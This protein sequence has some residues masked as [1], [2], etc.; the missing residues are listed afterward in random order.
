VELGAG[1]GLLGLTA[2]ALGGKVT[3][4]DRAEVLPL[5]RRGV[6]HNGLGD[7]VSVEALVWGD[8]ASSEALLLAAGPFDLLLMSDVVYETESVPKLVGTLLTLCTDVT[9]VLL[10]QD[11]SFG[12]QEAFDH[13]RA[14]V[15][16]AK[17]PDGS[18]FT[19]QHMAGPR[20]THAPNKESVQIVRLRRQASAST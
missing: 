14:C 11:A 15:E 2:A 16:E 9:E 8:Q 7:N 3:L 13:F 10:A 17:F 19:W 5:L 4:T 18:R 1:L 20:G 6:E 12:R